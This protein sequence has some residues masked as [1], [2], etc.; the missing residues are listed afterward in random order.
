MDIC[1]ILHLQTRRNFP[2]I[3][4]RVNKMT[5]KGEKKLATVS[6]QIG[7]RRI[8]EGLSSH[9]TPFSTRPQRSPRP[10]GSPSSGY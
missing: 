8:E 4:M 1:H 3:E 10:V 6:S 5:M 7:R 2:D 9:P